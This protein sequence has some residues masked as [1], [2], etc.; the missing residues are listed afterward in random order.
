MKVRAAPAMLA[1][2]QPKGECRLRFAKRAPQHLQIVEQSF[3]RLISGIPFSFDYVDGTGYAP[4]RCFCSC[5]PSPDQSD[6]A[7]VHRLWLSSGLVKGTPG[8]RTSLFAR[9]AFG[10]SAL[11]AVLACP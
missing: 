2:M 1:L 3:P 7:L 8:K 5:S 10:V 9:S 11:C 6:L 4:A